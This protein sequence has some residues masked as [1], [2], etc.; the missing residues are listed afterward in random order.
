M[1]G[2]TKMEWFGKRQRE[3]AR[4]VIENGQK[5]LNISDV[6]S[7][8]VPLTFFF[9][10]FRI[11][12]EQDSNR[13]KMIVDDL[14]DIQL[15][16]FA[17]FVSSIYSIIYWNSNNMFVLNVFRVR[18]LDWKFTTAIKQSDSS[19]VH[20]YVGAKCLGSFFFNASF[21]SL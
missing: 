10:C 15:S 2:S 13:L 21:I 19:W 1:A 6:S 4:N 14:I 20:T 8:Y 9:L 11:Y 5:M 7:Y 3:R 18:L 12:F 17:F 16:T